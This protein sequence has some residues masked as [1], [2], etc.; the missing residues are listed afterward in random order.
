MR[1]TPLSTADTG[2]GSVLSCRFSTQSPEKSGLRLRA[3]PAAAAGQGQRHGQRH[4]ADAGLICMPVLYPLQMYLSTA[5]VSGRFTRPKPF[6]RR[7]RSA[8][9]RAGNI[10]PER[11]QTCPLP[12]VVGA[13]LVAIAG[14]RWAGR[15]RAAPAPAA[16]PPRQPAR[17]SGRPRRR[18]GVRRAAARCAVA[19]QRQ[20]RHHRPARSGPQGTEGPRDHPLA[21]HQRRHHERAAVP[22]L[23]ERL[24]QRRLELAARRPAGH[25]AGA[26]AAGRRAAARGDR[27]RA[28]SRV[29]ASPP[30]AAQALDLTGTI[31]YIAP[32]DGNAADRTVMAVTLPDGR[33]SRGVRS[34]IE[35]EWTGRIPFAASRTGWIGDYF[36]F[37]QWFPEDRRARG[38]GLEHA[39][40]PPRHRVLRRLR[41]LRRADDGTRRLQGGRHGPGNAAR[42]QPRRHDH[43]H[44]SRRR[45]HR[46]RLDRPARRSSRNGARSTTR[47]S[48]AWRCGCCCGR[49][50]AARRRVTSRATAAA[51]EHFG[52]WFGAYP[53]GNITIVDPAYQS[54]SDGMEYPMLFTGRAN[55]LA[56]PRVTVPESTVIHETGHQWFYAVVATNEFEH[57]WMDEG[58][59]DVGDGARDRGRRGCP[60]RSRCARSAP[61]FPTRSTCRSRAR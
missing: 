47:R 60:T 51:L 44:L 45:R 29:C 54:D 50:T 48:R 14:L 9:L 27:R 46:L 56:P 57:G 58:H 23:L 35:I 7:C 31:R 13:V 59:D 10:Q 52:Q 8:R 37:G 42:G 55:W 3:A 36:F 4:A 39:P 49:S 5:Y 19:A 30:P 40:V 41:R 26:A 15:S 16:S 18:A 43:P 2:G 6:S 21:Q 33:R 25:S 32:D 20:L 1:T 24:A 53:Y 38:H 28:T 34:Q 11:A 12:F 17:G 22:P 61:S